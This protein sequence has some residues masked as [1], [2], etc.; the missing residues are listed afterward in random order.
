MDLNIKR[1]RRRIVIDFVTE[2]PAEITPEKIAGL[3]QDYLHL[4]RFVI[5]PAQVSLYPEETKIVQHPI[6][7]A[8]VLKDIKQ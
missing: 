2:Y 4:N 7:L 3:F 6:S 1:E 5:V 8:G